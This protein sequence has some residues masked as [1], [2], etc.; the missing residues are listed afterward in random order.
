MQAEGLRYAIEANRRRKWRCSGVSPWQFNEPFPNTACT[1]VLDYLGQPKPAYWWARRAYEPIH[2]S[3]QYEKLTWRPGEK[4][5]AE[6][7]LHHSGVQPIRARW[8][9]CLLALDGRE[10]ARSGG[11]VE[12]VPE[13]G[14]HAGHVECVLPAEVGV[15]MALACL[16][17]ERG[18]ILS[19]NEYLFS[20]AQPPMQPLLEA[21]RTTL[22]VWHRHQR[23]GIKNTGEAIALFVRLIPQDGQW[24]LCEDDYFCLIPGETRVLS[25]AGKGT[26]AVEAWNS[27]LHHVHL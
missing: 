5:Q 3:L 14:V 16:H 21:P 6:V 10:C 4:W 13:G 19:C 1:N 25:V 17:D 26:I 24:L 27:D 18:G 8:S 9:V 22:R 23:V 2:I 15:W 12:V 7:W 20:T 11:T